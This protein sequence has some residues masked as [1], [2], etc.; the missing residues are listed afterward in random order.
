MRRIFIESPC[1]GFG[2][3]STSISLAERLN[4]RYEIWFITFGEALLFL[5]KSTNYH[6]V[7][8]DTRNESE[9][10]KIK[11]VALPD[12]FFITNTNVEFSTYLISSSYKVIVIDTLYWMWNS[13][14]GLYSN[15][16]YF[17]IQKYFGKNVIDLP[18]H[19]ECRPIIN[20]SLW[21]EISCNKKNAALISFG[22]MSEPGDNCYIITAAKK[23]IEYIDEILPSDIVEVYVI[24]GLLNIQEEISTTNRRIHTL[25]Y[26]ESSK[27]HDIAKQC[28]YL[29][30]S[31]GLTSIYEMI[32]SRMPFCLLPGL[33]VSQVY[34]NYQFSK[35]CGYKYCIQWSEVESLIRLFSSVP[36]L[37]GIN[38]LRE[39]VCNINIKNDINFKKSLKEYIDATDLAICSFEQGIFSDIFKYPTV[40]DYVIKYLNKIENE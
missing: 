10:D 34:Q 29:F 13:V 37:E 22:G 6:F 4:D 23:M 36:E 30:L 5:Q 28:K 24:G 32:Y 15:Y 25:G 7:E 14:P 26:V 27:Y 3:I 35:E 39:Y 9:F 17:I 12:D 33:N 11:T 16:D 40:E 19:N 20:Y 38:H 18:L 21:T 1:F 2:P 8:I 31:P